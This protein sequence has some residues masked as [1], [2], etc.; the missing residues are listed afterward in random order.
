MGGVHGLG[1]WAGFGHRTCGG[2]LVCVCVC[3]C[4]A[5]LGARVGTHVFAGHFYSL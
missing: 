4:G 3:V 5:D 1:A 2:M